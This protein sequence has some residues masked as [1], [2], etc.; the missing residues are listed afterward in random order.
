MSRQNQEG[1]LVFLYRS[2][3]FQKALKLSAQCS[4]LCRLEFYIFTADSFV[5]RK[6]TVINLNNYR[7]TK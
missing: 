5:E 3:Y 4:I 2:H 7:E 6:N 1:I